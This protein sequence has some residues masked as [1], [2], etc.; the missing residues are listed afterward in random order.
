M[1]IP[2]LPP[3]GS[4]NDRVKINKTVKPLAKAEFLH[5]L[6]TESR[7][8]RERDLGHFPER[9]RRQ[10][11]AKPTD[12]VE[13]SADAATQADEPAGHELPDKG[14]LIDIEV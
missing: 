12:V 1:L 11:A 2:G 7:D 5:D 13:A 4:V 14:L 6:V 9:R 8:R 3:V 10:R